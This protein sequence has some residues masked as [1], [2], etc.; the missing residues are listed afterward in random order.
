MR[1][2]PGA[3]GGRRTSR[4][5]AALALIAAL[6]GCATPAERFDRRA[7][8]LDLRMASLP[9]E[10]FSHRIYMTG[11]DPHSTTLHV[12]IEHDGTPWIDLHR[13]SDDP[14]PRAPLA[15]ELMA[16]DSGPRLLL[17][18][19]CYFEARNDAGCSSVMWTRERYSPAVVAS[20]VAALR[21]FLSSHPSD[22]VVLIGYSGGGTLAWLMAARVPEATRVVTIAAN[23]DV[24]E[25]SRIHGYS[26]LAGSLNPALAPALAPAIDQLH[27]VGGRDTN[28]TPSVVA[29]FARRHPAARVVEIAEFDHR[30]C[31][32][33]R[34][35]QLLHDMR[36]ARW[37]A[38][39]PSFPMDV[40]MSGALSEDSFAQGT[41]DE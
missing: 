29:S 10:G 18:R 17:G 11:M 34:W 1:I 16:K 35:P 5:C 14:T 9:G 3:L 27:F 2:A 28:V 31:W 26:R 25:W 19:P 12:Y 24:D 6:A 4:R 30:C 13:V 40:R 21:G 36:A 39:G 7:A 37:R 41:Y 38:T 32:I 8:A 20:M 33:D 23:L 22:R 15:L